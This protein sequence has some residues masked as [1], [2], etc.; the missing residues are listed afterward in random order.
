MKSR[1]DLQNDAAQ[2]VLV[3]AAQRMKTMFV[4]T[5]SFWHPKASLLENSEK[6]SEQAKKCLLIANGPLLHKGGKWRKIG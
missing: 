6:S 2:S 3:P 4:S 5:Q 1:S